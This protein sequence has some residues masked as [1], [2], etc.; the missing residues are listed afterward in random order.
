MSSQPIGLVAHSGK[1]RAAELVKRLCAAF[2]EKGRTLLLDHGTAPLAGEGEGV[3]VEELGQRCA[4]VVVLGGDGSLLRLVH[5]FGHSI[6][7]V[8]GINHGSLGFLT[9]VNSLAWQQAVDAICSG[10]YVLSP[11]SL[12]SV[13]VERDGEQIVDCFGLNDVVISRG[14]HSRLI[15]LDTFID[16]IML[17]QYNA[18]GLI[19]ATP[20]GSTAYSLSAGGPVIMPQS[21]VFVI[22]PICP[23]VLTNRSLVVGDQSEVVVSPA[24]DQHGIV[25]AVD[26]QEPVKIRSG[27]RICL[28]KSA[29][30]LPLAMLP[31]LS[32]PEVL[33]E[34]LKWSGTAI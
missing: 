8:F 1:P 16:G 19:I 2:R 17:T 32:F 24:E 15:R 26:G 14:R 6:C 28:R 12:L 18:D 30:Q 11:R 10:E 25:L 13:T 34:K 4:V 21:G 7:P 5:Q 31:Q 23:H 33:R 27:D 20:T 9:C 22:T 29:L 3:S